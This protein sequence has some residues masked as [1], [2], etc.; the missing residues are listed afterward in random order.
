MNMG[1]P[2]LLAGVFALAL[3]PAVSAA[4]IVDTA[5]AESSRPWWP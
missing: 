2:V 1:L 4:D 5:V 3:T